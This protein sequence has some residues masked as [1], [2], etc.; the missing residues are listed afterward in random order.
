MYNLNMAW[1]YLIHFKYGVGRS[2]HYLG[3]THTTPL[4]RLTRHHLNGDGA[5]LI[6]IARKIPDNEFTIARTWHTDTYEASYVLEKVL[7]S[8]HQYSKFCPVCTPETAMKSANYPKLES[9]TNEN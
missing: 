5:K 9:A 3:R 2:R 6:D 7:K 8:R 1:C 4:E